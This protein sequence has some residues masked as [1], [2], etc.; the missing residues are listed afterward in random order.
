[1]AKKPPGIKYNIILDPELCKLLDDHAA[2]RGVTRATLA[3]MALHA[4]VQHQIEQHPTCADGTLCLCP[5]MW[6]RQNK[7]PS[8]ER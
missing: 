2:R 7:A 6:Q 3:R 1:M 8:L 5:V 4:Y